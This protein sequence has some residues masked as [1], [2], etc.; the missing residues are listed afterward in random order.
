MGREKASHGLTKEEVAKDRVG[1]GEDLKE[2][3]EMSREGKEGYPNRWPDGFDQEGAEF[4]SIMMSFYE[5]C[6]Q[7]HALVL[8]AIAI[9]MKLDPDF[10]EDYVRVGDNTLRL[11]H[12]PAVPTGAFDAG[13][14][15]RAGAHTDFGSITLLFQDQRGGLQVEQPGGGKWLDVLPIEG[16]MIVNAGDLLARWSNDLIRS[17]KHRVVEP[18]ST[19]ANPGG[20]HLARYSVVYFGNPDFDRWIDALPGTWEHK[21]DGKRYKGINAGDYVA[22]RLSAIYGAERK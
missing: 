20:G 9:G 15:I 2:S 1:G 13:S 19:R 4:K 10:F 14:R 16:T 17:T 11:L 6:K 7:I 3:F 12:Y 8:R 22:D 18:P 5:K 21:K